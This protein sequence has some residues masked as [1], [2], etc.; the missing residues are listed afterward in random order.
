MTTT[1]VSIRERMETAQWIFD[2]TLGWIAAAEV[3]VAAICA[4]DTAMLAGLGAL[5]IADGIEKSAWSNLF[6]AAAFISLFIGIICAALVLIPRLTGGPT[7]SAIYFG[8]IVNLTVDAY[9]KQLLDTP[10][11]QLLR[12]LTAQI[13]FNARIAQKKHEWV[14]QCLFWSLFGALPWLGAIFLILVPC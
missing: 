8:K 14:R 13:H 6:G 3:K 11:E 12:D 7:H 10:E 2:K 5:F 9:E 1:S 4:I